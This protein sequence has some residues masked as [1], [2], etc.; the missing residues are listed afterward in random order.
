MYTRKCE[1]GKGALGDDKRKLGFTVL[2]KD[3]QL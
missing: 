1:G 2:N 3:L